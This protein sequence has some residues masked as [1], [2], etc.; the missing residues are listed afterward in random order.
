MQVRGL[1]KTHNRVEGTKYSQIADVDGPSKKVRGIRYEQEKKTKVEYS[2]TTIMYTAVCL[3]CLFT[4]QSLSMP[5]SW[6]ESFVEVQWGTSASNCAGV[7]DTDSSGLKLI[8]VLYCDRKDEWRGWEI[9][10]IRNN[11]RNT[12]G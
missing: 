2:D 5:R 6:W 10:G 8:R 12:H 11:C 7:R 4:Y 9:Y 1:R 3:D